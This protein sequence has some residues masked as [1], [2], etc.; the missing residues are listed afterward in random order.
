MTGRPLQFD[1]RLGQDFRFTDAAYGLQFSS[2]RSGFTV[3]D[4]A[5]CVPW[6]TSAPE[7]ARAIR[8]NSTFGF[9][10]V[11]P[12][13]PKG[14]SVLTAVRQRFGPGIAGKDS[15][16]VMFEP[17]LANVE[18]ALELCEGTGAL[19]EWGIGGCS[20]ALQM[21][22]P[23]GAGGKQVYLWNLTAVLGQAHVVGSFLHFGEQHAV[24]FMTRLFDG[25]DEVVGTLMSSV[26][27]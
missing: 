14:R 3:L 19:G 17:T 8:A 9:L 12:W 22:V 5:G 18:R 4:D 7:L 1:H 10:T 23:I 2:A 6:R 21:N 16:C 25:M 27:T 24:T 11:L 13:W 20:E 26:K 15:L